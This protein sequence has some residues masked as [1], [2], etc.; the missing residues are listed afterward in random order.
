MKRIISETRY[1][2]KPEHAKYKRLTTALIGIKPMAI[3]SAIHLSVKSDKDP[4]S[5]RHLLTKIVS[6][7]TDPFIS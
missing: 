4:V 6:L 1:G 3:I 5:E 2:V 7:F